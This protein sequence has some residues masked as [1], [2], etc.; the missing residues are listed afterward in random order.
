[1]QPTY[2]PWIGYFDLID[3][4]DQFVYYD[5]VQVVRR[6]WAVRNRAKQGD[7][8]VWL[9]VD[10]AHQGNRAETTFANAPVTYA[11][12]WAKKHLKTLAMCYA[13]T[14]HRDAILDRLEPILQSEPATLGELNISI[15]EMVCEGLGIDTERIRSSS[16]PDL[17][18]SKDQ[19][20][21]SV[22]QAIGAD[23]YLSAPGSAEYINA[24]TPG[25]E[26]V[27]AGIDLH[28]HHYAHPTYPQGKGD[29]LP[30]LCIVDLLCW[31]GWDD[32]LS[33]IRSGRR[34][35]IPYDSLPTLGA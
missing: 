13:K 9:A 18:G 19:R 16:L 20:L 14:P 7:Q 27:K 1:M 10:V 6:S 11:H 33:V 17:T 15:I 8:E 32:A 35:P 5:D 4:V 31:L 30:Y 24:T 34:E 28:Y 12:N 29:F 22:C 23:S 21:V 3:R 2:L 25:G 26:F